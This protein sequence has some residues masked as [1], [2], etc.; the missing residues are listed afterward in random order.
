MTLRRR[1]GGHAEKEAF[2]TTSELKEAGW[3]ERLIR[4]F[5]GGPDATRP[6]PFYSR[7]GAPMRLWRAERVAAVSSSQ[8]VQEALLKAKKN[9]ERGLKGAETRAR[10]IADVCR[11][12]EVKVV[13]L[14]Y[15]R[16][17]ELS[18]ATHGGNYMGDPGPWTWSY[19]AALNCVRHCCTNYEALWQLTNRGSTGEDG[20]WVLRDRVDTAIEDAYPWLRTEAAFEAERERAEGC[21][22]IG[23]AERE[24]E[25]AR[26]HEPGMSL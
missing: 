9:R 23:Q 19:R 22:R 6:N 17:K 12:A 24:A 25:V 15:Q 7:A 3:T 26:V 21:R 8:E 11:Q 1:H 2:V 18:A 16:V 4:T 13:V 14:P 5:L 10:N 20:Y